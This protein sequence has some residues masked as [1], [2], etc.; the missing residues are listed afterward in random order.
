MFFKIMRFI[1][2]F[3][4]SIINLNAQDIDIKIIQLFSIGNYDD[5]PE[6]YLFAGP[7]HINTDRMNNIYVADRNMSKIRVFNSHGKFIKSI[8]R[9]GKGPGE[10]QEVS[11]MTINQNEELIVVDR[12]NGRFTKFINM[13]EEIET[14]SFV[15]NIGIFPYIIHY[16]NSESYI[17]YYQKRTKNIMN[18]EKDKLVHVYNKDFSQIKTSFVNAEDIWDYNQPFQVSKSGNRMFNMSII[19]ENKIIIA[20]GFYDGILFVYEN[21]NDKWHLTTIKGKKPP[22]GS[23]K[24]LNRNDYP[25]KK[26]PRNIYTRSNYVGRF[27]AQQLNMSR[28]LFVLN[29][30]KMIHFVLELKQDDNN[31]FI[32]ELFN[33][34]GQLLGY[35][36]I[37]EQSKEIETLLN[38]ARV[39]WKDKDDH[40][41]IYAYVNDIPFISVV[42]LDIKINN[43]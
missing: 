31:I 3:F 13:G 24:L 41:Y 36:P 39:L 34:D 26:Y 29:D 40:F 38:Q 10:M 6:E 30:G 7:T 28:G 11:C 9:K 21:K 25:D 33:Q 4:C 37:S 22:N 5:G 16:L 20:D 35:T 27:M 18:S 14:Y 8:G 12:K 43:K 19:N 42:A 1:F 23:Y 17:I 15:E 32:A 2:V